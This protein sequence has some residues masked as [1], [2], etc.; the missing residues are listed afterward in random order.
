M[1]S[2]ELQNHSLSTGDQQP[3]ILIER[4][5]EHEGME[6]EKKRKHLEIAKYAVALTPAQAE[7]AMTKAGVAHGGKWR[8]TLSNFRYNRG[9]TEAK[10]YD[11]AF[12][13]TM[14]RFCNNPLLQS[15]LSQRLSPLL[16]RLSCA[17]SFTTRQ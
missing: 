15:Q 6:D 9:L 4:K 11:G 7:V 10:H 17:W 3:M 1:S 2:S 8:R 14:S 13:G 12:V 5:G 16:S